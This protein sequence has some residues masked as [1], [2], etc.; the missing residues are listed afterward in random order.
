MLPVAERH[1]LTW[2]ESKPDPVQYG[3]AQRNQ[4]DKGHSIT[5]PPSGITGD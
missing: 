1:Y 2:L 3:T 4:L 5:V